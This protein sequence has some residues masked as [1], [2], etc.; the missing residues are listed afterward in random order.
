LSADVGATTDVRTVSRQGAN[1]SR[2][3]TIWQTRTFSHSG[4]VRQTRT[5]FGTRTSGHTR[6]IPDPWASHRT[7]PVSGKWS[8]T[9]IGQTCRGPRTGTR[10]PD[11]LASSRTGRGGRRQVRPRARTGRRCGPGA[12]GKPAVGPIDRRL[13]GLSSRRPRGG[14]TDVR[15]ARGWT[16]GSQA[17]RTGPGNG[18]G[19]SGARSTGARDRCRRGTRSAAA[20]RATA[21]SL[22]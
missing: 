19:S 2:T 14:L 20:A 1:V 8:I 15:P 18:C 16:A 22:R 13:W 7:W 10:G 5:I 3:G 17:G 11:G 12:G 6:T 21:A 4:T 9:E